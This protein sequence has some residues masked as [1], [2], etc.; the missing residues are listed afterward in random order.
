M[1]PQ[2]NRGL[3][4]EDRGQKAVGGTDVT[5][6]EHVSPRGAKNAEN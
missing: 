5:N 4:T 2:R 3:R 1:S 6:K